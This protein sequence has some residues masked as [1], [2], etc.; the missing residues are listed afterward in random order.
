M[1]LPVRTLAAGLLLLS[2]LAAG[3][4]PSTGSGQA[5]PSKPIRLLLP[6]AGG[7]DA[8]ARLLAL[9]LSP[10]LGQQVLPEQRLG[11]GGNIAHRAAASAA[12]DGYT[13]LMAA[14]PLVINPHLNPKAGFDPLRDF[15]PVAT[16]TAIANVLVVHPKVAARSL[17]ELIELARARPGKLSYGSG[18]VGSSNHLAVELLKSMAKID[19][20]H[21][22]YKSATLA[23]TGLLAGEVDVVVVAASSVT[24]YAKD[25]RLRALAVLDSKRSSAMP[26][27]P[28]AAQAGAPLVAVNW[29]VLLAPAGTPR[30]IVLRLNAE[31][32]RA[33]HA[34]DVRERLEAL[35]GEPMSG[36][37]ED[38]AAFLKKEYEQWGKVIREAGI[39]AD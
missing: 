2:S 10:A 17:Q 37:P 38:A 36:S 34:A 8:V 26:E 28:T 27:V 32:V 5:Y 18:G 13:L 6:F 3:Q 11:A 33:M 21:V 15:A 19:I 1:R 23:L 25:G 4:G 7:T 22:P 24:A 35:G 9:K 16:L 12:P 30:E 20:L 14:P 31:A 29:Y 39:K